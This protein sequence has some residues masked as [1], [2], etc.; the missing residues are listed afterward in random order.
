MRWL[1]GGKTKLGNRLVLDFNRERM[2]FVESNDIHSCLDFKVQID[3]RMRVRVE[4][5]IVCRSAI[6]CRPFIREFWGRSDRYGL[7][8]WCWTTIR[9]RIAMSAFTQ[10]MRSAPS[11]MFEE[12]GFGPPISTD[13][14]AIAEAWPKRA[15]ASQ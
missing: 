5:E 11:T 12:E 10:Q 15:E 1:Y 4:P 3:A 8:I 14:R 6:S 13:G 9:P 7:Q 2:E